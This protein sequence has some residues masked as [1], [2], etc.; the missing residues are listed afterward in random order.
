MTSV[1]TAKIRS[2]PG[3]DIGSDH[4]LVMMSFRLRLKEIKMQGP[5]RIKFDLEKLNDRQ[6][7]DAFQAMIGGKFAP[8]TLL[9]AD[10]TEVDALVNSFNKAL[11]ESASEILGKRRA[12]E[13]P[14]V[15]T[16]ILDLCDERRAL[17]K[18]RHETAEGASK[19]RAINQEIKKSIKKAKRVWVD[20]QCQDIE[21]NIRKNDSKK[22]YELVK[23]LTSTKQGKTNTI[24]DK[25]GN[26]LTET[27]DI[28]NRWTE[29]CA[30]LYSHTVV[31][32]PDVLTVPLVTDTDNYPIFQEEVEEA[33]K[34]LKKGKSPGIDD[35]PGELLQARGDAVISAL[36]KICNKVWQTG[37]WPI[38]WNQSLIMTLPKKG[39]LQQCKNYRTIQ[40]ISLICHP[41]KVLLKVLLNRLKPQAKTII[42]QE[43][44]GL[45]SGRSTTEQIFNLRI[46]YERYLQHQQNFYHLFIDFKKAF[47]RVLHKALWSTMR[48][49]N[50]NFNEEP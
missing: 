26:C 16:S 11:T 1:N 46:L 22:A 49:Y 29:Y 12:V 39:N 38:L 28:L 27:N 3:A 24:Q 21:D 42:A 32:D 35:I 44:A 19:Y 48:L 31:G 30:E 10:D 5:T 4:D 45:R 7:A 23:T 41:S 37:E 33:V 20:L 47:D 15:K 43:Q 50:I 40:T 34:S 14:W 13:R 25:D 6:V 8:L 2:F 36:H 9:N 17:K 18:G